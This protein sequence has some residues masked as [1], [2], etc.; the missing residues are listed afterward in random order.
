MTGQSVL[1]VDDSIAERMCA[2]RLLKEHGYTV[3]VADGVASAM[4]VL[5]EHPEIEVVASDL[6]MQMGGTGLQ[7]VAQMREEQFAQA[8]I[9]HTSYYDM[10]SWAWDD[11][12]KV[13]SEINRIIFN[14]AMDQ[15]D[16][17]AAVSN[18]LQS[19][20]SA[21]SP[22]AIRNSQRDIQRGRE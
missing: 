6:S 19:H 4:N 16:I 14:K 7:L 5:R 21:I 2:E 12:A 9:L 11:H 13:R 8:F 3:Y 17:I 20:Q 22:D 18:V 10:P 1:F 15:E